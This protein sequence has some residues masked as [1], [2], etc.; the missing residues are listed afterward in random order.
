MSLILGL[1]RDSKHSVSAAISADFKKKRVD[2]AIVHAHNSILDQDVEGVM[3]DA[4]IRCDN[5]RWLDAEILS[6]IQ[7]FFFKDLMIFCVAMNDQIIAAFD[8]FDFLRSNF[9]FVTN[10]LQKRNIAIFIVSDDDSG[11]VVFKLNISFSQVKSRC[12]SNDKQTYVKNLMTNEKKN[13]VLFCG[14][15]INDAVMLAQADINVHMHSNS[16]SDVT[17]TAADVILMRPH[18]SEVL[19]LF[20]LFKTAFHRMMFNFAW[21]FIHNLFAILL[22]ADAV[23][24]AR[25]PFEYAGLGEIVSVLPIILIALQP[26]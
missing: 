24:K 20:D 6:E 26:S 4:R 7:A 5:T 23:V 15:E 12:T 8:F 14:D 25:I 19:I 1:T 21:S 11:A 16:D 10:E 13:N 9:H 18:L 2:A 17:Q 22:A 3:N